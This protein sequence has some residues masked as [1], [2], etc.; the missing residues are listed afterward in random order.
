[1][2][3]QLNN[4]FTVWPRHKKKKYFNE[5]LVR[6]YFAVLLHEGPSQWP[7]QVNEIDSDHGL[8]DKI[9]DSNTPMTQRQPYKSHKRKSVYRNNRDS[10][11][12]K[13]ST[14]FNNMLESNHLPCNVF[15]ETIT[16][17]VHV[18]DSLM[19]GND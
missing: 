10:K 18:N 14:S 16:A 5:L 2:I 13:R 12:P 4:K 1:M 6:V 15:A 3:P 17:V 7:C 9:T 19:S 11:R 8:K